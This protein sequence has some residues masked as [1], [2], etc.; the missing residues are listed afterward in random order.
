M[1][2]TGVHRLR[3]VG[4]DSSE[5]QAVEMVADR[6]SVMRNVLV[7]VWIHRHHF[8]MALLRIEPAGFTMRSRAG[9]PILAALARCGYSHRFG[10]RRG[11][12]GTCKVQLV[13]GEVCYPVRVAEQV[14]TPAERVAG[15]CLSCRAV[16]VGDV[17]IR[18][19]EGDR[20]RN[21]APILTD[22]AAV[23]NETRKEGAKWA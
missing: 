23:T 4:I 20:L 2:T 5:A 7:A 18:L 22:L 8:R 21:V 6:R 10:C 19:R 11:G 3:S 17:V 12:C 1:R 16:P 9:E 13:C 15:V 14:L